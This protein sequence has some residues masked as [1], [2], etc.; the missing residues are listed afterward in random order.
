MPASDFLSKSMNI[1]I[2]MLGEFSV[3]CDGISLGEATGRTRRLWNLLG[4]LI[5]NRERR[6]TQAELI[7]AMWPGG[8]SENPA[9]ALKNLVYRIRS[10]FC[11]CGIPGARDLIVLRKG[12]YFWNNDLPCTIDFEQFEQLGSSAASGHLSEQ[13]RIRRY[14][15]ALEL[16][17]GDF[18]SP[19]S[20][21]LW[22]V[23]LANH[24]RMLYFTYLAKVG[25]LLIHHS[26]FAELCELCECALKIDPFSE[27]AHIL[28]LHGLIRQ[29]KNKE[30]LL[31][32]R[33]ATERFYSELGVRP[34]QQLRDMYA[35]IARVE[36]SVE[37]DIDT[38]REQ[39]CEL[40]PSGAF[41]C[42]YEVFKNIYRLEARTASRFGQAVFIGL[43]TILD[44]D[45]EMPPVELLSNRMGKLLDIIIAGL[46]KGDVVSK[47][48]A[49]QYIVMLPTLTFENGEMVMQRICKRFSAAYRGNKAYLSYSLK[50]LEPAT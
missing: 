49:S 36:H 4:F 31:H 39:L 28:M 12:C 42:D 26:R 2:H 35:G 17:R 1:Q 44:E 43:L 33:G 41:Y 24:Y 40:E 47:F 38:I 37:T 32:Y 8:N 30:A 19:L 11:E 27:Q 6:F 45:D 9:N 46:R 13:E 20:G 3:S 29:G 48:S 50:P 25:E 21:E 7:A 34:S 23:P 10:L 18:M 5:A 15:K 22:V 14:H 16:Y